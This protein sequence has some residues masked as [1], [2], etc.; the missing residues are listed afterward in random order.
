[1]CNKC[2]LEIGK[3]KPEKYEKGQN[4]FSLSVNEINVEGM[5]DAFLNNMGLLVC[6]LHDDKTEIFQLSMVVQIQK[7]EKKGE[8]IRNILNPLQ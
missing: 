4:T 1:M 8:F 7:G 5:S 3:S 2:N 6:T